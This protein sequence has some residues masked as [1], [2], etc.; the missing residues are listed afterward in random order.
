MTRLRRFWAWLRPAT[1]DDPRP[2]HDEQW[3]LWRTQTELA[4]RDE[5]LAVIWMYVNTW[6]YVT[7]QLTTE[8]REMWADAVDAYHP[9]PHDPYLGPKADRWWDE[10]RA[11]RGEP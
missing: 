11:G 10:D 5:L 8:Q 7:K 2:G 4:K 1:P 6:R 9:D 3:E